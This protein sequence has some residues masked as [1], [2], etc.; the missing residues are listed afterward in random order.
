MAAE[1]ASRGEHSTKQVIARIAGAVFGGYAF[2][3]GFTTLLIAS[4]L[5]LSL[6]YEEA[7]TFA[8]LLAV[9]VFLAAFLWAFAART[10]LRVWT[11]LAGGG[12]A[13]T[14]LAWLLTR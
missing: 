5:A 11:V 13:M 9:L 3:W 1:Q 7:Q 14:G 2:V 4:A 10:A 6:P 8:Y 12:A